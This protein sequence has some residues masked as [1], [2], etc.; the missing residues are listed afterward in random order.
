MV[1]IDTDSVG[2]SNRSLISDGDVDTYVNCESS[3]NENI[4][5]LGAGGVDNIITI[6]SA[7]IAG[8][9]VADEDDMSSNSASFICTQQS[10]KAYADSLVAASAVDHGSLSGLG[11]DDHNIYSLADGTRAF[12]GDVEFTGCSIAM[13]DGAGST[14]RIIQKT[15]ATDSDQW[16]LYPADETYGLY[17]RTDSVYGW[18]VEDGNH[19]RVPQK[20]R[21]MTVDVSAVGSGH[22]YTVLDGSNYIEQRTPANVALD[23]EALLDHGSIQGLGDDDHSKYPLVTD[24]EADRATIGTNWTDLTDAGET[25]L[26]TH[27]SSGGGSAQYAR[28]NLG[29]KPGTTGA[30]QV[31][32]TADE[33]A[34]TD[35]NFETILLTSVS[36]SNIAITSAG[37]GGL[38]T[39][40]EAT[41]WYYIWIISDDDGSTVAGMFSASS[42]TPTMPGGYTHKRLVGEI[43]NGGAGTF[44]EIVRANDDVF[45][46]VPQLLFA[47]VDPTTAWVGT[48]LPSTCPND[49]DQFILHHGINLGGAY[50][51]MIALSAWSDGQHV[52][53]SYSGGGSNYQGDKYPGSLGLVQEVTI[54]HQKGTSSIYRR[55]V[56]PTNHFARQTVYIMA[57]RLAR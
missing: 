36:E 24:F 56:N 34:V 15:N 53:M 31:T 39:G 57:Y 5:R 32:V 4:I 9:L 16:E 29:I 54:K 37:A 30:S 26:H 21:C 18:S 46:N 44:V 51:P 19:F 28:H 47:T 45:F 55:R 17:N 20:L 40:A 25:A 10:I 6:A 3:A 1:W 49:S 8:T 27:A 12:T 33:L 41:G 14:I 35:T 2:L 42:T 50:Y 23:L 38:D 11:D 13:T 43:Y 22:N 7:A 48:T 52:I